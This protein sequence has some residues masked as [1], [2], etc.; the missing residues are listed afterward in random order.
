MT[1]KAAAPVSNGRDLHATRDARDAEPRTRDPSTIEANAAASSHIPAGLRPGR[2]DRCGLPVWVGE[3]APGSGRPELER[4]DRKVILAPRL[5]MGG[6]ARVDRMALTVVVTRFGEG[7][8][9]LHR[10]LERVRSCRRC[11]EPFRHVTQVLDGKA[12]LRRVDAVAGEDGWLVLGS[13]GLVTPDRLGSLAGPR[14]RAHHCP[15][16]GSGLAGPG[17]REVART[18]PGT[19]PGRAPARYQGPDRQEPEAAPQGLRS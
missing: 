7:N 4:P 1:T 11:G 18:G 12:R 8:L 15:P 13:D 14:Y 10:C 19:A 17:S 2:H 3:L 5:V 16:G 6:D 9:T